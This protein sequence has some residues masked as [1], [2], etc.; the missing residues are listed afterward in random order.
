MRTPNGNIK[1]NQQITKH[2]ENRSERGRE[3]LKS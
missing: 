1:Q 2:D 3:E